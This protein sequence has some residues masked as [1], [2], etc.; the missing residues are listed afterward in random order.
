MCTLTWLDQLQDQ[1][2]DEVV[3]KI[4]QNVHELD[5]FPV[6]KYLGHRYKMIQCD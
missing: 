2:I 4:S 6:D 1:Q 3:L 5:Y